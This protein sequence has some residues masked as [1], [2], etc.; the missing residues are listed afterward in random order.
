MKNL[1]VKTFLLV[2]VSIALVG[3]KTRVNF[4]FDQPMTFE[5]AE[6]TII[7]S[8]EAQPKTF[9][10]I[11]VTVDNESIRVVYADY[12]RSG[13]VLAVASSQPG[14]DIFRFEDLKH[15]EIVF[16]KGTYRILLANEDMTVFR[17]AIFSDETRARNFYN[18]ILSL[19][20]R[21]AK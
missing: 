15:P 4:S 1:V 18:A 19:K 17:W 2:A 7:R 13:V 6:T 21:A 12:R 10:P 8:F 9:R 20:N 16:K 14:V 5:N 11:E 3:C